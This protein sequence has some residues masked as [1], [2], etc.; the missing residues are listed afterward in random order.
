MEDHS[1]YQEIGAASLAHS[2]SQAAVALVHFG[3]ADTTRKCL[4]SLSIHEGAAQRVV[5]ADHGPGLPL[6]EQLRD[7]ATFQNLHLL[8]REN[9][10]FG[11]GCNAAAGTAFSAGA[12]WVWFLNNDATLDSPVL[13]HLLE[14]ARK[15]PLVGL[16][17]T[18]QRDGERSI[19]ADKLPKW[20]PTPSFSTQTV[21]NLPPGCR[22]LGARETLS[23][24]SILVSREA[25]QRLG[26]WPEW[27]FLYWE[28]VAW[29]LKAHEIGIPMVLTD[30]EIRHPRNTS[31]GHHSP[32]TTYYGVRNGFLL[33]SELWPQR[34]GQRIRQAVHLLQKRFSQGNWR[35]L[36]PTLQGILDARKGLRFKTR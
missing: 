28:D 35:M 16:W 2:E 31:T 33:H 22:Q 9:L 25:W 19:G 6:L 14:L 7:H 11:S 26:L 1:C 17:G 15:N 23:G 34:K 3:A 5:I 27:C 8:R 10:G 20:F 12:E 30:L 24:A 36:G 4:D 32:L 13:T 21:A 18:R 29:C